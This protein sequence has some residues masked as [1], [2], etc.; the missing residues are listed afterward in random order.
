MSKQKPFYYGGQALIEG[1]MMRGREHMAMAVRKPDGQLEIISEPL[2]SIYKGKLR[3]TPFARGVIMLIETLILGIQTMLRSAQIATSEEGEKDIPPA[4]LWSSV[5]IALAFAIALFFVGP[6]LL[7]HYAIDPFVTSALVSNLI[8][9]LIRIGIFIAYLKLIGLMPDIRRVFAYHGAEHKVV[10]S[11]EAGEPLELESARKYPTAHARCG[12]SF[13]L[14]VLVI[15]IIVFA[16][17]GRP[18]IWLSIASRIVL[19]PV[20]AAFG[21]EFVRFGGTHGKNPVVRLFLGPGLW[22]QAMTTR[23]P[24]DSQLEAAIV[25]LN[26]VIEADT[27]ETAQE[28]PSL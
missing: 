4:A 26:R 3:E 17:L 23:E 6:L 1:V 7:T 27:G 14:A 25:A 21:Y 18:N 2:S 24:D 15:A 5:A 11:Y 13:T 19:I 8:E 12:T 10:N 16:L 9:G 20:I 22:L 28:S